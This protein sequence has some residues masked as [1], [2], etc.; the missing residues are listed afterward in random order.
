MKKARQNV[1]QSL[2]S[3]SA[4]GMTLHRHVSTTGTSGHGS[5][6]TETSG[7]GSVATGIRFRFRFRSQPNE[8]FDD[9]LCLP[10][11]PAVLCHALL[12]RIRSRL[13][14]SDIDVSIGLSSW[15]GSSSPLLNVISKP[16]YPRFSTQ[17]WSFCWMIQ[18]TRDS[19]GE[20]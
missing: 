15:D 9:L 20:R 5:L 19:Q 13:L 12:S 8:A 1:T 16:M 14:S 4:I 11:P 17:D 18:S 7:Q 2:S 6:A 3:V 10:K